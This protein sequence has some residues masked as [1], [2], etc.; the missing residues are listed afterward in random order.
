MSNRLILT[1]GLP[2]SGKSTWARKHGSPIV[3]PD[4]IRLATYGKRY[5]Q[6]GEENVWATA[7]IMVRSLFLAGHEEVIVDATNITQKRRDFWK[8]IDGDVMWELAFKEIK[9]WD[10]VAGH[11]L[12]YAD[13]ESSDILAARDICI[14][15]AEENGDT[16]I[17]PV[18]HRM[19]EQFEPLPEGSLIYS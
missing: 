19:A 8:P 14:E 12:D 16:E 10:V 6:P 5:W 7:R 13:D 15:R 17:I 18:I 1:V 4:S 3:N 9:P 11:G 2:R